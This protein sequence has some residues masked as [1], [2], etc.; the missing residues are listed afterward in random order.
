MVQAAWKPAKAC[1]RKRQNG[2]HG[3]K[4]QRLL[5]DHPLST[6]GYCWNG[7]QLIVRSGRRRESAHCQKSDRRRR[8]RCHDRLEHR[9]RTSRSSTRRS[10]GLATGR[11]RHSARRRAPRD[12][13]IRIGSARLTVVRP[14]RRGS[15]IGTVFQ[16]QAV[17]IAGHSRRLRGARIGSLSFGSS[18]EPLETDADFC[19]RD[20]ARE[21]LLR[22]SPP[23]SCL[24]IAA[25]LRVC[26][27]PRPSA[28]RAGGLR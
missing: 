24:R 3:A 4:H 6:T 15:D 10:R 5:H 28:S 19:D 20:P 17:R 8:R 16:H 12:R 27:P 1:Q 25:H 14:S 23:I 21:H 22:Q 13:A 9:R 18:R 2:Q 7:R 26:T 11:R